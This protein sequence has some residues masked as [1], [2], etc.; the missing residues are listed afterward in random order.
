MASDRGALHFI[1]AP[2]SV[3]LIVGPQ[4]LLR[5]PMSATHNSRQDL[6]P[7]SLFTPLPS[8]PPPQPVCSVE[9][10]I[11]RRQGGHLEPPDLPSLPCMRGSLSAAQGH[12]AP[13]DTLLGE[14]T[15]PLHS[16]R[17]GTWQPSGRGEESQTP[18][19]RRLWSTI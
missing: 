4:H 14:S 8:C 12:R 5:P 16:Q 18:A 15:L 10:R 1:P 11:C 19:R 7:E 6:T 9:P 13:A 2:E 17:R 3:I